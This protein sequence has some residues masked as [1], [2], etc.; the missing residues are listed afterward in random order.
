M[1]KTELKKLLDEKVEQYNTSDFIQTDPIQIV[2]QFSKKQDIEI[3]G[4]LISTIAWGNRKSIIQNGEKLCKIMEFS[5]HDFL[6][7]TDEKNWQS[8]DFVH[9]TFNKEDL[10]FFMNALKTHYMSH[11]SLEDLFISSSVSGVKNRIHSFRQRLLSY[12]HL[13]RSEKHISD[14]LAGSAAKRLNMYLRWMVRND[15]QGIDFGIWNN[16]PMSELRIPLDVHTGNVARKLGLLARKQNDWKA[17]EEIH[18]TLDEFDPQ[19]PAKYDFAL[20]GLGAFEGW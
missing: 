11:G 18:L 20:F 10:L 9:R 4:L 1:R 15:H 12:P 5:P 8:I 17:L 6:M 3:M 14:P 16:I 7:N 19:D 2:H 13:K